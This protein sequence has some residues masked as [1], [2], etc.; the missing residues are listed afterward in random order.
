[1][2]GLNWKTRKKISPQ[3]IP[4]VYFC[5]HKEDF[6]RCF[7]IISDEILAIQS[8]SIWYK[9][10]FDS[11]NDELL[12]DLKQMQLFVMPVTSKLLSSENDAIDTEFKL[13]IDNHIPVLPLMQEQG[14]EQ[15]FNEK[16]G[17]LQFLDKNNRDLTAISYD[18]KLKGYLESVLI[19]DKLA[20][21]IRAAFDAYVFLSYR[22]KDRR[23]A[24]ELMRLIH[25][26]DFCRDIAIW[27]D[28]F[29]TPGEN[30]NSAIKQA[31]KKSGL[32]VLA[33]TPNLV[34]EKNYVMTTEYPM[35][36]R[37]RKPILPIELVSTDRAELSKKYKG[38]P[39]CTD[40]YNATELSQTLLDAVRSI[41]IRENDNSPEHN[42]FIGLAYL[43]G[44]DVEVDHEKA[45]EL[46]T[47]A[48]ENNLP[49]A[50]RKLA[51]MHRNGIGV[52]R[53]NSASVDWFKRLADYYTELLKSD[54]TEQNYGA[55]LNTMMTLVGYYNELRY[56]AEAKELCEA[57]L[58]I[59]REYDGMFGNEL[60]RFAVASALMSLGM[61]YY[62]AQRPADAKAYLLE[63]VEIYEAITDKTKKIIASMQ[64]SNAYSMLATII[65]NEQG[66]MQQGMQYLVNAVQINP[67]FGELG[68]PDEIDTSDPDAVFE[69]LIEWF[70][71]YMDKSEGIEE[72]IKLPQ[73]KHMQIHNYCQVA[74]MADVSG[75]RKRAKE[76]YLKAFDL[77]QRILEE[78]DLLE[79]RRELGTACEGLSKIAQKEGNIGKAE[80]YSL[81]GLEQYRIVQ[82]ETGAN[83][84]TLVYA[85]NTTQLA[86]MLSEANMPEKAKPHYLLALQV[87]ENKDFEGIEAIRKGAMTRLGGMAMNE[88][89]NPEAKRYFKEVLKLCLDAHKKSN[90]LED[91]ENIRDFSSL[92]GI[93]STEL[94]EKENATRYYRLMFTVAGDIFKETH[95]TED[96]VELAEACLRYGIITERSDII[97]L[98]KDGFEELVRR[99]PSNELYKK[100][101]ATAEECL[102]DLEQN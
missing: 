36:R 46:I 2:S 61:V 29:L 71:R 94:D 38:I 96:L 27:Y 74:S 1:M 70:Y 5:C 63:S 90:S 91:K 89:N 67:S 21:K 69:V 19:G 43:G 88:N 35:A 4:K 81:I 20:Q 47:F 32:F 62:T 17:D 84:D 3:G 41:A 80:E 83:L 45:V 82:K 52:A 99:S 12:D 26:N 40:A 98:A 48:A 18:E 59:A 57:T 28:E 72:S 75:D 23:Y 49:E 58:P 66:D 16:C 6:G 14:L 101:L 7:D 60:S 11:L 50:M 8:C 93:I 77:A 87:I 37:S 78:S 53:D 76:Y 39:D 51:D 10:D 100:R 92:L 79:V 64:L 54:K 86:N 97:K 24:Q 42:F 33:V 31:L 44:V 9:E 102:K 68:L 25:K 30:F 34:N 65:F 55:C 95:K 13:A 22:K 73:L 15:L 56:F 85:L